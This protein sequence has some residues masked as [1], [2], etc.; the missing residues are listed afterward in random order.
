MCFGHL[1]VIEGNSVVEGGVEEDAVGIAAG[2]GQPNIPQGHQLVTIVIN[3]HDDALQ[4]ALQQ[5]RQDVHSAQA[6]SAALQQQI[7]M[8][9]A[10]LQPS[11]LQAA[12][13][14]RQPEPAPVSQASS[15][16][17]QRPTPS[18]VTFINQQGDPAMAASAS[19]SDA[20]QAAPAVADLR[21]GERFALGQ[22][23]NSE[24]AHVQQQ[25]LDLQSQVGHAA[26]QRSVALERVDSLQGQLDPQSS[27]SEDNSSRDQ[28][29]R[30]QL[31]SA[32]ESASTS[33]AE[34]LRLR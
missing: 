1:Q 26:R 14:S 18:S 29:L 23:S 11:D 6:Q 27:R 34:A 22:E 25:L 8:L 3:I 30:V 15:P 19:A 24:L 33:G 32:Q 20:T 16:S 5:A 2:A 28:A 12:S 9:T 10:Q 31:A 17:A 7:D 4:H 13:L 21:Q